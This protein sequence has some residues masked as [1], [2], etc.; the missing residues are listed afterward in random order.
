MAK[1]HGNGKSSK[2]KGIPNKKLS[3][4][5]LTE[6]QMASAEYEIR[7]RNSQDPRPYRGSEDEMRHRLR[8]RLPKR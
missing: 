6:I 8:M 5:E 4:G 7:R 3:K 1:W 2:L